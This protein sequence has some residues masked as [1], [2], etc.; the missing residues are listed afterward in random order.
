MTLLWLLIVVT[1]LSGLVWLVDQWILA[2]RRPA[3]TEAAGGGFAAQFAGL[4]FVAACAGTFILLKRSP[5]YA[6]GLELHPIVVFVTIVSAIILMLDTALFAPQRAAFGGQLPAGSAPVAVPEVIGFTRVLCPATLWMLVLH[7]FGADTQLTLSNYAILGFGLI[8]LYDDWLLHPRRQAAHPGTAKPPLVRIVD[9]LL[10]GSALSA[11]WALF[12]TEAVDFSLV[13]AVL[14][15]ASGVIWM[16]D[17]LFM[18]RMRRTHAPGS[19]PLPEPV[20]VE[21]ARTFFPIIVIVL[22]VRSFV[23]EPFRIPSDSMMPTLQ[24]GDFIFVNK[25]AYGLRLPVI[26][27]KVTAGHPPARGDVIVFRLPSNPRVNY[28]KR[29][30]ALP[31]EHVHVADNQVYI[32][33]KRQA[34][35]ITG[36]YSGKGHN[37]YYDE[38]PLGMEHLGGV[39]H[40]VMYA[41]KPSTDFD[42]DVPPGDYVFMGDNRNNSQDSRF[43]YVVGFVPEQNLVGRAVRVWFNL[44]SL[45]RIGQAIH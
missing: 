15:L 40:P 27:T 37:E 14:A 29:L 21:Y 23:F 3:M 6:S 39:L 38:V 32:D 18:N 22:G 35:Q 30:V 1:V 42:A 45:D 31:G 17:R 9:A 4:V 11:V 26:N 34:Q 13:L 12:T 43:A 10:L 2:P 44:G 19:E 41:Q 7:Y 20:W 25:Y 16:L 24:D 33:G 5:Q 36:T 8:S 28:I